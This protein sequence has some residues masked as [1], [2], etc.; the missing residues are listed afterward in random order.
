MDYI[1]RMLLSLLAVVLVDWRL[2]L[3]V[4]EALFQDSLNLDLADDSLHSFH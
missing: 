4:V 3:L 2:N 1:L